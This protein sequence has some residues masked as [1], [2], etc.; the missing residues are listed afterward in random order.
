MK[1]KRT[2]LQIAG[3]TRTG[4]RVHGL[5][6]RIFRGLRVVLVKKHGWTAYE[7]STGRSIT[8]GSWAGGQ[9]NK[10]R[11]GVLQIVSHFLSNRTETGWAHIERQLDYH[12]VGGNE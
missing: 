4:Y 9:S 7:A 11:M 12:L 10:T 5:D 1:F 2:T 3:E 6:P 8:P